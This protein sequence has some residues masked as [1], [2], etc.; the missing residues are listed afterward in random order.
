VELRD[1][2][3]RYPG[4]SE[5]VFRCL[6][7]SLSSAETIQITG[8][9]GTGKS[10]LLKLLAGL[11]KPVEGSC[12]YAPGVPPAYM[13]QF[14]GD[15]LGPGLT[16]EEHCKAAA[17]DSKH[18][19]QALWALSAFGLGLQ[20]RKRDFVGHLSGGGR[21]IVALVC[22][23]AAGATILC[24]DEFTS[25]LDHRSIEVANA[26]LSHAQQESAISIVVVS[27]SGALAALT[28]VFDVSAYKSIKF[29][30]EVNINAENS[31]S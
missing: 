8:R 22:T 17:R 24:L 9:N 21:Q 1:A 20:D 12:T 18:L 23:L 13:D 19:D 6:D 29:K 5:W 11:L 31:S 30:E 14:A 4:E 16:V 28:R 27:H 2:G 7:F 25:A 26:L 10:T 3:Y 15:M